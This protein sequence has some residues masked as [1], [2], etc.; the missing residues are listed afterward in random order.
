MPRTVSRF[1]RVIRA[2]HESRLCYVLIFKVGLKEMNGLLKRIWSRAAP[3][4]KK[5]MTIQPPLPYVSVN[6]PW[7][8]FS[9]AITTARPK[10]VLEAGTLQ[11]SPGR[12]TH[13]RGQFPWVERKDY[14]GVDLFPGP[15][16]DV[17]GDLHS[18]PAEWSDRFDCFIAGAVFEHLDR[19][20]IAAKEV[21]R[22]LRKGGLFFVSTHQT[23]PCHAYPND[24]F[25]FSRDA[26]RLIFED[27]GLTVE[28]ADY[29]DRCV[30]VPPENIVPP[31]QIDNWNR[32]FPSFTLVGVFGRK[33]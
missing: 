15:D 9:R 33:S 16:V 18:L 2:G 22:V 26:L 21:A 10:S 20:W 8:C 5:S 25:R 27:A 17:V 13:S 11:A 31:Q 19:P 24:F 3:G 29:R 7:I 12:S 23:F 14:V 4:G 1:T 6:D 28:A 32:D 30:I